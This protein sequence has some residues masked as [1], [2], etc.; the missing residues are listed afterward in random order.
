MSTLA[1]SRTFNGIH[2][3]LT[4]RRPVAGVVHAVFKGPDVGEFGDAPFQELAL[5]V[6]HLA[7]VEI[8]ID[9]REVPAA[10]LEVSADW[11]HWMS[12]HRDRIQRLNI[13]CGSKF[14][15]LTA[16]F[17]QKFTQFGA[18]MRIYTDASSFEE[19]L[20]VAVGNVT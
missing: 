16:G 9:A 17:V 13:L 19:A 11:A 5:D 20:R 14:I 8:F 1:P 6:G 18:R 7:P 15:E 12:A 3:T 10:S 2:C 4:I